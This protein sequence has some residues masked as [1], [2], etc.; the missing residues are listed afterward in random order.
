MSPQEFILMTVPFSDGDPSKHPENTSPP[1]QVTDEDTYDYY[2][3]IEEGEAKDI[4]WRIKVASFLTE[5][6]ISEEVREGKE[7]IMETFPEGYKLFEHTKR[8]AVRLSQEF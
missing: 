3:P 4:H 1:P 6:F 7:Y 2:R 5:K 8:K